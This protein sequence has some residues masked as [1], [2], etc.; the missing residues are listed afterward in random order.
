MKNKYPNFYCIGVQ[1]AGTTWLHEN[2]SKHPAI[3]LPFLKEVQY[4]NH[5]YCPEHRGWTDEHRLSRIKR[6]ISHYQERVAINPGLQNKLWIDYLNNIKKNTCDDQWYGEIFSIADDHKVCGEITPEYSLLPEAGIKHILK[7]NPNAKFILLLRNP[8]ERDFS[9]ARMILK[10]QGTIEG[11][12]IDEGLTIEER[13][14]H[15]LNYEGVQ[16]RS[17]YI[18]IITR[19]ERFINKS[20]LHIDVFDRI[21]SQPRE[22]IESI[23]SFLGADYSL[24]YFP[25]LEK[26]VH[27]GERYSMPSNLKEELSK[28]HRKQIDYCRNRFG[29]DWR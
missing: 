17:N 15:I 7:L 8:V 25:D 27:K 23:C 11:V 22:F 9:H 4:F 13:L 12:E 14:V 24:S 20:N 2:L 1:K 28:K 29:V 21:S 18:E 10:N 5:L 16:S 19:W 26:V 3:F 6:A